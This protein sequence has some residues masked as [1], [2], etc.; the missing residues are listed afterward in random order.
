MTKSLALEGVSRL[1]TRAVEGSLQL[2]ARH[3]EVSIDWRAGSG[4]LFR[5]FYVTISGEDNAVTRA[6]L[7]V[8]Y[9]WNHD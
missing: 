7:A 3:F 5:D 6:E 1:D 4:L 9:W 2:M 8:T